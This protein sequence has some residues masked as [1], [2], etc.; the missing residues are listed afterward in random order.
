[1]SKRNKQTY[2]IYIRGSDSVRWHC[3]ATNLS[4]DFSKFEAK[5][6][7]KTG[8]QVARVKA[9]TVPDA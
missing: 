3:V 9:G 8:V 7:E 2:D 5:T 1:M 6:Y 4:E